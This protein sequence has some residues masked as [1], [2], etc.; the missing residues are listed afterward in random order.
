MGV[1]CVVLLLLPFLFISVGC[2]KIQTASTDV[3]LASNLITDSFGKTVEPKTGRPLLVIEKSALDKEFLLQGALIPQTVAA[4]GESLRTRVVAFKRHGDQIFLMEATSGHTVTKDLPQNLVLA[5]FPIVREK[6]EEIS[7]DFNE[8]MT[9][10]F[11]QGDWASH[12]EQPNYRPSFSFSDIRKSY[13]ES[14]EFRAPTKVLIRQVAQISVSGFLSGESIE[15]V[16]VRY[17]LSPYRKSSTFNPSPAADFKRAG[18]FEVAPQL[19]L[20]GSTDV[21]STKFDSTQTIEFA[22]SHNTPA[23]YKDAVRD[24][25]LYWKGALPTIQ[26]V[27]GAAGVTAPSGD[28]NVIQWVNHDRAGMAYADAQM[29]PRSGEVLRAQAFITST[30]AFGTRSKVRSLIRR[31]E[32][33]PTPAPAPPSLSLLG[34]GGRRLCALDAKEQLHRSMV[35]LVASG[36]PDD[37]ILRVSQDFVRAVVAHEVG[38]LLGLRHNFAGSLEVKNYPHKKRAEIFKDYLEKDLVPDGVET[39]STEMDYLPLE[40]SALHG[41]QMRVKPGT[42]YPYDRVAIEMLYS[43]K[44]PAARSVPAFCTDGDVGKYVDCQRFDAGSNIVE[45]ATSSSKRAVEDLPFTFI[46]GFIAMKAPLPWE[47]VRPIESANLSPKAIAEKIMGPLGELVASFDVSKNTLAVTRTFPYVGALNEEE[48]RKSELTAIEAEVKELGGWESVLAAPTPQDFEKFFDKVGALMKD[49]AY[50]SGVGPGG[51]NYTFSKEEIDAISNFGLELAVHL[52]EHIT[53]ADI[54]ML[55]RLPDRW[56]VSET[57]TGDSLAA[58]LRK[59]ANQYVLQTTSRKIEAEVE[60]PAPP[61]AAGTP[62]APPEGPRKVKLSLPQFLYSQESR[63]KAATLI[64]AGSHEDGIDWGFAE[65]AQM[66]D[67]LKKLL[68]QSCQCDIGALSMDKVKVT[69]PKLR[70]TVTRWFLENRKVLAETP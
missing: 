45:F 15:M 7:F 46:E 16:E 6:G 70:K 44:D 22:I 36:A 11:T 24:G 5:A 68:N 38:H 51:Q 40:E 52:P 63:M 10:I 67:E 19:K 35:A 42:M 59:R 50:L 21:F 33:A 13:L 18:F 34:F 65:R 1:R 23:E 27:D 2:G 14:I 64:K 26:V 56:K 3:V 25:I 9:A 58:L 48:V 41:Q 49:P 61:A 57:E 60:L 43:A 32:Q 17:F 20:D 4:M 66:K 55:K 53:N 12:S 47:R 30:F 31:L 8:G 37:K 29:D 39:A 69:D 62:S 54:A 28:T